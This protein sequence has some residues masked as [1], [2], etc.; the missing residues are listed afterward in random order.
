TFEGYLGYFEHR[1]S[2]LV[3][4]GWNTAEFDDRE[5]AAATPLFKAERFENRRDP[6]SPY[7]LWPRMIPPLEEGAPAPFPD[8]YVAGGGAVSPAWRQLLAAAQPLT[9]AAGETID[10]VLDMG[11]LTTAFPH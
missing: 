2:A 8:A 6:A 5:W 7:G 10:L 1:V 11:A 9:L 3:P 4:A